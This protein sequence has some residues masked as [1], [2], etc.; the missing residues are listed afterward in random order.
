MTE[1]LAKPNDVR[2]EIPTSLDDER[3]TSLVERAVRDINREYAADDSVEFE[4]DAHRKD[5]EAVLTALRIATRHDRRAE[6]VQSGSSSVDY[7]AST[8]S[9][10][11]SNV[12]QLDPGDAFA[13]GNVVRNR[14][15]H[16]RSTGGNR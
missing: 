11:R 8:V 12:R 14:D 3:I 6:S 5:F 7:E 13:S 1:T 10:I 2:N 9:D 15:R 4:D 16:T